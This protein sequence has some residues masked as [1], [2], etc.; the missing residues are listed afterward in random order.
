MQAQRLCDAL[1]DVQHIAQ[2]IRYALMWSMGLVKYIQR[3]EMIIRE[4]EGKSPVLGEGVYIDPTATVIG[5]VEIGCD[6][7]VWPM[8]VIRGDMHHIKIGD[9]TSIQDGAVCHITHD[10]PFSPG[11]FPL[12]V[13]ND[14]T[15]GHQAMLHGCTIHDHVLVGMRATVLD[16]AVVQSNVII[17]AG[18]VVPGGR[19]LESGFL[20]V[21]SPARKIR[22]LTD[23]EMKFFQY[24]A[25][26]Y[27]NLKDR[28]LKP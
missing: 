9:R 14:V 3:V 26:N 13:G 17:G 10:G 11:G 28:Y 4:F 18:S 27:V 2:N 15:V 19:V 24:S 23:D 25:D 22:A 1:S 7:S 6:S 21:G 12:I 16:G 5:D 8:A 20:W